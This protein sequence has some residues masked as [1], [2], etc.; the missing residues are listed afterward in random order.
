LLRG[1]F[2]EEA[3]QSNLNLPLRKIRCIAAASR[4]PRETLCVLC[5]PFA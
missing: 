3:E 5:F 1:E 2:D 4:S